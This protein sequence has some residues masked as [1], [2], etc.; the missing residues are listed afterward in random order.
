MG[1]WVNTVER[2]MQRYVLKTDD[3]WIWTAYKK[4]GYG[5][6]QFSGKL[7]QA[8]RLIYETLKGPIPEGLHLDHL[9]RN[10]SCVNP[11]HLE[12]VTPHENILR[13]AK[14]RLKTHCVKG[15]LL[16]DENVYYHAKRNARH[17]IVC[18]YEARRAWGS[19]NKERVR[20]Y[21]RA[22]KAARKAPA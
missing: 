19:S 5:H 18:K 14:G 1:K 4:D 17:C 16:S 3:C 13:G 10:R 6:A 15:H 8:H 21:L 9:C 2:I 20:D 7:H 12:P 22:Y 11:D